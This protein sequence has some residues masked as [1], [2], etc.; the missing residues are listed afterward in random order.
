MAKKNINAETTDNAE[1][2]LVYITIDNLFPHPDNPRKDLGDLTELAESIKV[3]GV[4]QNLTVVPRAEGGY[5]VI[6]GHRRLGAAKLAGLTELPCV[7][8]EMFEQEQIATMLLENIQRSDLT[9]FEQAQGFQ[10]MID[11]GD[12]VDGIAEKTGFSKSTVRRRLKMAELDQ[13]ILKEVSGRQLSLEDIDRLAQIDDIDQRNV[14]LKNIGTSNFEYVLNNKLKKQ[15]IAK[16]LPFVKEYVKKFHAK[17]ITRSETYGSKYIGIKT[18]IHFHEWDLETPLVDFKEDDPRKLFYCIDEDYGTIGFF[19]ERPNA[20]SQKRPQ[21]EIDREK[22]IS[23]TR[24]QL[25]ELAADLYNLR[26]DFIKNFNGTSKNIADLLQGAVIASTLHVITYIRS[27]FTSIYKT[28]G[29]ENAGYSDTKYEKT[30]E[31]IKTQGVKVYPRIV[32][33]AF[34]DSADNKYFTGYNYEFP[35]YE[36]NLKLNALYDWLISLGYEM[37]D[38]EKQFRSGIHPLFVD[39]D[40]LIKNED[41]PNEE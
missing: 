19:V 4:M 3:K 40:N 13:D 16:K 30:L 34:G 29:V 17:K 28:L 26:Y 11:F 18:N 25:S 24:T 10:M 2:K 6:I 9:V 14:C 15:N 41:E 7:I 12:S 39:K 37:S 32:Y 20:K 22:Y 33:T 8:T 1:K 38:V 36:N 5:T 23:E 31:A 21:A 27:D 35:K